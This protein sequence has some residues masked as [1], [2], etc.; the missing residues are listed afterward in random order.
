MSETLTQFARLGLVHHM[1][2]ARSVDDPDYHVATLE[3]LA[4]RTDIETFDCCL[5]YGA[6]RQA[7]LARAIR[8]SG[9]EHV[10]FAIHLFPLRKLSLAATNYAEQAQARLIIDDMVE[11]AATIGATG[12]VFASGGPPHGEANEEH[13][14]AF[15]EFCCWL[16]ERLAPHNIDAL[17]EPFDFDHDKN[18]LYGPLDR[19]LELM[20]RL[21]EKFPNVGIELDMAHLPLMREDFASAI[22]RTAPWLKRVHLG[23]CVS[24]D[25]MDPFYGDKHPPIGYPGGDIDLPQLVEILSSLKET[26]FLS[27]ANRGD[28]LVE[29]N[30]FPGRSAND[31]VADN[32]QRVQAAWKMV[33]SAEATARANTLSA[34]P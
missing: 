31:S 2:H 33:V 27:R 16:C 10:A 3:A 13:H 28:L 11:Q 18:F 19:S 7:R 26:G 24:R 17:L 8:A 21:R 23:N 29:I 14:R 34:K 9:K 5:P 30:P 12:F 6:E 22:R 25:R 15:F 32:F 1:L 20:A 4:L